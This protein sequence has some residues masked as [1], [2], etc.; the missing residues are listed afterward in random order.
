MSKIIIKKSDPLTGRICCSGSKNAALPI[1]AAT[2]LTK[3]RSRLYNIPRLSD[4]ENMLELLSGLGG[5]CVREG[6]I[7]TVDFSECRGYTAPYEPVSKFRGSFLLAGPLLSRMGRARISM[8][9]GCP[10]GNRPI[11]LHLKGFSALGAEIENGHG[12][13]DLS[14]KRLKGAKIYLDFPSVGATENLIMAA[15]LADGETVIENA[16]AEPEITDL[17]DFLNQQGALISGMGSD[18]VNIIGVKDLIPCSHS[19]ISDRIEAGTFMSAFAI[20]GGC[21]EITNVNPLH[22]KPV[23]A[24]L[25]EMGAKIQEHENSINVDARAHL[26]SANIKTLPFP[27]FPTDMQAQFSALL[28]ETEGTSIIV[29]TVFENRFLHVGELNRMGANIR[30]DGRSSVIEGNKKLSG[31]K[32]TAF[33]LRGGASLVLAGLCACG[34]TEISGV[35]HIN[36][37]Y[38]NLCGKLSSIGANIFLE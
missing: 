22:V 30:I 31:S 12:Y 10:I 8:P 20:T 27:G 28:C 18:T 29:E 36:R 4:I 32:V 17:A 11:D 23:T 35:E 24:K 3:G 33:D 13:V 9:G 21:G 16:A 38:E 5:K 25:S 2:I 19:V 7:L 1:L 37:G 15:V 6:N 26:S 34:E 14:C